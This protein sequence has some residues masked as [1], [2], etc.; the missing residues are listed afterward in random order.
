M[1]DREID[2]IVN[3]PREVTL[4]TGSTCLLSPIT[5]AEL[6]EFIDA[7]APLMSG[8]YEI[9][10]VA[11]LGSHPRE[12]IE[13]VRVG[14]RMSADDMKTLGVDDLIELATVIIEVNADFFVRRILPRLAGGMA[15]LQATLAGLT[16]LTA[17]SLPATGSPT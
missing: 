3:T 15:S 10:P 9:D 2:Q 17:S 8:G 4:S 13:A 6:P 16:S 11:L 5:V 7:L 12:L 1:A 14:A